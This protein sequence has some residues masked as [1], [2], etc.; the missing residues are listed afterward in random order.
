M[1]GNDTTTSVE[2]YAPWPDFGRALNQQW[3]EIRHDMAALAPLVRGAGLDSDGDFSTLDDVEKTALQAW[4][5]GEDGFHNKIRHFWNKATD[6]LEIQANIPPGTEQAPNWYTVWSVGDDGQV[7]QQTTPTTASNVGTGA[8]VFKQKTG[9]DLQF[10]TIKATGVL[11]VAE[12]SLDLTLTSTAEANTASSLGGASLVGTKVGV[13]LPFKGL[14]AGDNMELTIGANSITLKSTSQIVEFY[15]IVVAHSD[16]SYTAR[17]THVLKVNVDHFYLTG[18]GRSNETLLNLRGEIFNSD[19]YVAV[20]GDT[21]T[22]ALL[23]PDGS[24]GA[25]AVSFSGDTN[26]GITRLASDDLALVSG[27]AAVLRALTDRVYLPKNLQI[28]A[29]GT[30]AAPDLFF[31][32][33]TDS[34]IYQEGVDSVA[35]TTGGKQ[36]GYFDSSQNLHVFND[37]RSSRV[38]AGVGNFYTSLIVGSTATLKYDGNLL[39]DP[40]G[41]GGSGYTDFTGGIFVAEDETSFSRFGGDPTGLNPSDTQDTLAARMVR[42]TTGSGSRR[43]G[44]FV[45][46]LD[47]T[48]TNAGGLNMGVNGLV[49][50]DVTTDAGNTKTTAFGGGVG[51]RYAFRHL[52]SGLFSMAGGISSMAAITGADEEGT[53]T[54]AYAFLSEG[55]DGGA[56]SGEI[57]NYYGFWHK[58][59]GG[60]VVNEFAIYIEDM[61]NANLG[62]AA[63]IKI[64]QQ[65][66]PG[67]AA[68]WLSAD[69]ATPSGVANGIAWGSNQQINIYPSSG[70]LTTDGNF[71]LTSASEL[72]FRQATTGIYSQASDF[73][74]LFASGAVRIGNSDGQAPTTYLSV[75]PDGDVIWTTA[76]GTSK[77][78][79]RSDK[80]LLMDGVLGLDGGVLY[81]TETTTPTPI[82]NAGAIYTKANNE[83]FFQDGAGAEHSVALLDSISQFYAVTFRESGPGRVLQSDTVTFDTAGFYVSIGG[84]GKPLVSPQGTIIRTDTHEGIYNLI[85]LNDG[86]LGD[87]EALG[88]TVSSD[89]ATITL[90]ITNTAPGKAATDPL[91]LQFEGQNYTY[92]PSGGAETLTLSAG[93]ATVPVENFV[94]FELS[95]GVPFLATSATDWP[96]DTLGEHHG[97]VCSVVVQDAA[98]V[99]THGALKIHAWTDHIEEVHGAG[100]GERGER[101]HLHSIAERLRNEPAVWRSGSAITVDNSGTTN[102]LYVHITS[103]TGYQMHRHSSPAL[104]TDA[105]DS[106]WVVNDD[107]TPYRKIDSLDDVTRYATGGDGAIGVSAKLTVVLW[108]VVNENSSDTKLFLN[109]PTGGYNTVS[110]AQT[111]SSN[112]R[113]HNIPQA[114][115][116]TSILLYELVLSRSGG[117]STWT[118]EDTIDLRG[119]PGVAVGG[120][121]AATTGEVNT[122][123]N[124]GAGAG[125]FAQKNSIDLEFKSLKSQD[126]T[127]SVTN[128][129][130]EIFIG[131]TGSF[132]TN[133]TVEGTGKVGI[134]TNNPQ[135]KLH[136]IDATEASISLLEDESSGADVWYDGANNLFKISTGTGGAGNQT[137]RFSIQR[138]TGNVGIGT[139]T[140]Q[141]GFHYEGIFLKVDRINSDPHFE[142]GFQGNP[143]TNTILGR[144]KFGESVS[145][146]TTF[147]VRA[148][149][150]AITSPTNS[151][152]GELLFKTGSG[153]LEAG[154]FDADRNLH[155]LNDVKAS[156]VEAGHGSFYTALNVDGPITVDGGAAKLTVGDSE[157]G[158]DSIISYYDDG[159]LAWTVGFDNTATEFVITSGA[160]DGTNNEINLAPDKIG[161]FNTAPIAKQTGVGVDAASIHAALVALGLISGP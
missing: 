87:D 6:T 79:L 81:F 138:D 63:P 120:G 15:G 124:V 76:A 54:D 136:I 160:M 13:D 98:S 126:S 134:G 18:S 88:M 47:W 5:L 119:V 26:T 25:P 52:S 152:L 113:V 2:F 103:G 112:K 72:R 114:Y 157:T 151:D 143:G 111:D 17:G 115:V 69:N 31:F 108:M 129:A 109:V 161:F 137:D 101:G 155:V 96:S 140:P 43:A 64:D 27:G 39:I 50:T 59:S 80:F 146:A 38:E 130:D 105:S 7:T 36:A 29:D 12:N 56:A 104:D 68:I 60:N 132:Y 122:A 148:T 139:T 24:A 33:D 40:Q 147:N 123:S 144:M 53:I 70:D 158:N 153:P 67:G 65:T 55:G 42:S 78:S 85:H 44:L 116:G 45:M 102:P 28:L 142:I 41:L 159:A 30:A 21:M 133:V 9:V 99:Q 154:R 48:G 66:G 62:D 110:A 127:I 75:E 4:E 61:G 135:S 107:T 93:S 49:Y 82:G 10:R 19:L 149:M 150:E 95:G 58:G 1:A 14:T 20:A 74:D 16:D 131:A 34:G 91:E 11:S 117:G 3:G 77:I 23:H 145:G 51:G 83:L 89:G 97:R 46:D 106:I 8:D 141:R 86:G 100:S 73:L 57:T 118:V 92:T 125:V 84:D 22:G 35:F 71:L 32:P 121:G 156:R 90:T 128:D 37:L 94:V